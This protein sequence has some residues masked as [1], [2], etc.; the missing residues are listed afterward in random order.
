MSAGVWISGSTQS[1]DY[2]IKA[3]ESKVKG[4]GERKRAL[5]R[6]CGSRWERKV[7]LV[8]LGVAAVQNGIALSAA[9]SSLFKE[10]GAGLEFVAA[11]PTLITNAA[12][13]ASRVA[14]VIKRVDTGKLLALM[15]VAESGFIV[16]NNRCET[17]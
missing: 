5:I 11:E 16:A 14:A 7:D 2:F 17:T 10:G 4:D 13:A 3:R 6:F 8:L 1:T 15:R 9:I 12:F